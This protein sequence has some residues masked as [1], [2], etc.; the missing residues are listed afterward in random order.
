MMGLEIERKFLLIDETWRGLAPGQMYRQG[1]LNS[2]KGRTVRVRVVEQL[3][4]LTIKGPTQDGVRLEY[5]YE[6]PC[7]D[8]QEM[9]DKLCFSP[10]I[11]KRRHKIDYQGFIW[12]VDEFY[13]DNSGLIF[14]EIELTDRSQEFPIPPWI[15]QE[16]TNDPR[17]YNSNLAR[18]P[19]CHW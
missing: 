1:Y 13:G 12:E 18:N 3:G 19:Y 15:G 10:I 16:V 14:A 11:E 4:F 9:L 7:A 17:Y 5:E 2:E 6:I 8:A